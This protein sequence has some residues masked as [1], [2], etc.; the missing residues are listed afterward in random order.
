MGH[1]FKELGNCLHMATQNP[2]SQL[3]HAF[4]SLN[5]DIC[6]SSPALNAVLHDLSQELASNKAL[7]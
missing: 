7:R 2:H 3:L 4:S 1:S 6:A 5:L